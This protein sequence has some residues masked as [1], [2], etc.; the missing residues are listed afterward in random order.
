MKFR[1]KP[2]MW[3]AIK[4][5]ITD[6]GNVSPVITVLRHDFKN[7]NTTATVNTAPSISVRFNPFSESFTQSLVALI[8]RNSTSGGKRLRTSS[9]ASFTASPTATILASCC[10]N[11]SKLIARWPSIRA[12]LSASRSRSI[13]VPTS[14]S[15][16][17][18]APRRATTNLEN[19][20]TSRTRPWMRTI[21]SSTGLA[22][23]PT[24]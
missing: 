24:G 20:C 22:N 3:I 16:R 23:K 4:L 14:A 10:L 19:S 18:K 5:L 6:M 2:N 12:M 15:V 13:I 7:K 21:V 17:I 11:I 9:S 8:K 1:V